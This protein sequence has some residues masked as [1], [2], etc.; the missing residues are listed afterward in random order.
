MVKDDFW[1]TSQCQT[2]FAEESF[3]RTKLHLALSLRF[4]DLLEHLEIGQD[5]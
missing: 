2:E 5:L 3:V 4:A 1:L